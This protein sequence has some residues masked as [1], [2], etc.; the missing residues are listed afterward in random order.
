[1]KIKKYAYLFG[2]LLAM[3]GLAGC[4]ADMDAP[5]MEVPVATMVANTSIIELKNK[6]ADEYGVVCPYKEDNTPYIIHGRVVSSDATGNIYKSLVIQDETAA[7]AISLNQSSTYVTYR[8][9]QEIVMDVTGLWIGQYRGLQQLGSLGTEYDGHPQL[10]FMPYDQFLEHTEMNGLP[11]QT[12]KYVGMSDQWPSDN[13]YCVVSEIGKLPSSGEEFRKMQS[14]LVEFRNVSFEDGG[15]ETYAP[16]QESVSRNLKDAAGNTII[17]R[18]S[19]YSNFYNEVLPTGTGTVRGILSY[20]GDAWQLLLRSTADVIFDSKGS[21]EKPYTTEEVIEKQ[22]QG[23]SGWMKGYIVGSVKGGVSNVSSN[24]DI[25][26]GADAEM[27]NNLVVASIPECTEWSQCVVV[28]LPQ[29]SDLRKYGNLADNPAVY[30]KEILVTGSFSEYLGMSGLT[31]C[32]GNTSSF[33]IDGVVINPDTPVTPPAGEGDG[34]KEKPFTVAQVMSSSKDATGVWIEGYVVGY[35]ADMK[36]QE[37]AVFGTTPTEGSNNYT[38]ATNCILSDVAPGSANTSNSIPA[39]LANTGN[40]RATL[41][42]SKNPS[43]YGKKVK[44]KGD[45]TKYFGVRG[46]KTVSEFEI[47]GGDTPDE[48]VTPP[49]TPPATGDGDGSEAKPFSVSYVKNSTADATGVWVEGY[50][51]GYVADMKWEESAVFG[52]TPTEGSTNYTNATNCI[53]SDVAPGS[54]NTSNSVPGGLKNTGTVRSTLGISK[55]PS[56]Y[57]KRVKVRGEITKYFGQR[58]IKNIDAYVILD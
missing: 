34:S 39:G 27:D 25:I 8:I 6:F 48:P 46:V 31:D 28:A 13:A 44:V 36:W 35:V 15:K 10:S 37:S 55:N 4:Q 30:K 54:A 57:G 23:Y 26:F 52:T 29:G 7:M 3:S 38:N 53:L 58:G 16:Y 47:I 22:N 2:A 1:M 18:N 49:V 5:E 17:V 19:G 21:K 41:G 11:D 12:I 50:V 33:E 43:I 9:G 32:A 51:V 45:V 42:I 14:Q 56:I 20:Y 40:V 24:S